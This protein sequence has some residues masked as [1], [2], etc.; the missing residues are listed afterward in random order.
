MATGKTTPYL[1]TCRHLSAVLCVPEPRFWVRR[2]RSG[3]SSAGRISR[4]VMVRNSC[5]EKPYLLT[6]ASFT[7]RKVS[8]SWSKIHIGYEFLANVIPNTL[9]SGATSNFIV[10]RSI[11]GLVRYLG[12]H[13]IAD[14]SAD[15]CLAPAL[16]HSK[17]DKPAH[18][19]KTKNCAGLLHRCPIAGRF[20]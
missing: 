1:S 8:V 3:T 5:R 17:Y 12:Q 13:D 14:L 9:L 4:S 16:S 15:S 18:C 20:H 7:S 2:S 19:L 11:A 10:Q 6:A